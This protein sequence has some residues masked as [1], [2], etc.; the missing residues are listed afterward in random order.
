[1]TQEQLRAKHV[2]L[3]AANNCVFVVYPQGADIVNL[4]VTAMSFQAETNVRARALQAR[5]GSEAERSPVIMTQF[6]KGQNAESALSRLKEMT[7]PEL[8]L[9]IGVLEIELLICSCRYASS[10]LKRM[11]FV[12]GFGPDDEQA[13]R[14]RYLAAIKRL[15]VAALLSVGPHPPFRQLMDGLQDMLASLGAYPTELRLKPKPNP[16]QCKHSE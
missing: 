9:A 13:F 15:P 4:N 5:L 8:P 12:M 16:R 1:M 6:V 7:N 14:L 11:V 2:V 3:D 10:R